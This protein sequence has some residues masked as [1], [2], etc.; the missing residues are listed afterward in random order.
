MTT[1]D[2]LVY[3]IVQLLG[4]Y[5]NVDLYNDEIYE[6]IENAVYHFMD[7]IEFD[8][9]ELMEGESKWKNQVIKS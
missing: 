9:N 2:E 7:D 8:L 5:F 4:E 3:D 1:L 6:L